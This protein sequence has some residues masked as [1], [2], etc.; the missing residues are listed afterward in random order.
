MGKELNHVENVAKI[1]KIHKNLMPP[2]TRHGTGKTAESEKKHQWFSATNEAKNKI[3]EQTYG[4]AQTGVYELE[5]S[6][7]VPKL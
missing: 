3:D 4:V 2:L 6:K 7:F 1:V 5:Y